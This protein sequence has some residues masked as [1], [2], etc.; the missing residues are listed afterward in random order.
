MLRGADLVLQAGYLVGLV[1]PSGSGK[2]SLIHAAGL[3][4]KPQGGSV[5]L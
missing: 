1:G 4:E 2:S 3:L 5:F